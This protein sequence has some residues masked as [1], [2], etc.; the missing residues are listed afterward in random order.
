MI[1]TIL[2]DTLKYFAYIIIALVIGILSLSFCFLGIYLNNVV[3]ALFGIVFATS[4]LV[5]II[6][7]YTNN[8]IKFPNEN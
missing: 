1:K 2:K 7:Y 3:I 5:A 6:K 4:L 8:F